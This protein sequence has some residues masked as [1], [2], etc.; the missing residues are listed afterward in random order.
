MHIGGLQPIAI[1]C[2]VIAATNLDLA[3]RA[4]KGLFRKDLYYRLTTFPITIP[5]L[6][7]RPE[8]IL[9]IS[10]F[11][12]Q[13]FNKE[14]GL[15]RKISATEI[16]KLQNYSFPGNIREL[17]NS[18]KRSMIMA[19]GNSLHSIVDYNAPDISLQ[20]HSALTIGSNSN[21]AARKGEDF[22]QMISSVEKQILIEA[23]QSCR[24]IRSLASHLK[25]TP[26]QTYR[27]LLKHQLTQLLKVKKDQ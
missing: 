3:E 1:N 4:S 16:K 9:G 23:I 20:A 8:D 2:N 18:M 5:P 12:L 26:S 21:V 7:K 14:Y 22:N 6:R 25:M 27:K 13:K 24:T 19:E 11:F 15:N 17:K 10:L